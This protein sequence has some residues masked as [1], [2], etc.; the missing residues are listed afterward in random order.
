PPNA[1]LNPYG[2]AFQ[3]AKQ[4][5]PTAIAAALGAIAGQ[6]SD[7]DGVPNEAEIL[8]GAFPGNPG[9]KPGVPGGVKASDATFEDKVQV[10]WSAYTNATFQLYRAADSPDGTKA[11]IAKTPNTQYA[12]TTA[13]AGKTYYYWI[14][15]CHG[16]WCTDFSAPDAGTKKEVAAAPPSQPGLISRRREVSPALGS[17]FS[18][19]AT[20]AT[21]GM[22]FVSVN[23]S[24]NPPKTISKSFDPPQQSAMVE[25]G[26]YTFTGGKVTV[27]VKFKNTGKGDSKPMTAGGTV[28]GGS[29]FLALDPRTVPALAPGKTHE[30]QWD[31]GLFQQ[32]ALT[33]ILNLK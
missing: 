27:M 18:R 10:A 6:D 13:A 16:A 5:N 33:V 8:F 28:A 15:A 23:Q 22:T 3:Q 25:G 12:D 1:P 14:K 20:K 2:K 21:I 31:A 26:Y 29:R 30:L 7:G 11:Q 19:I 17:G 9:S 24:S 4:G 32:A